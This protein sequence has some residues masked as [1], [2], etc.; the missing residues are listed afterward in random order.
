MYRFGRI[1]RLVMRAALQKGGVQVV[2]VNDPF[3]TLEYMVC[4]AEHLSTNLSVHTV[5]N[6]VVR[7]SIPAY[8]HMLVCVVVHSQAAELGEW[9][10]A[11]IPGEVWGQNSHVLCTILVS[12]PD[13]PQKAE[14]G[15]GV[16]GDVSCHMGQGR[17][18]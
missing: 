8:L 3:L 11:A 5:C 1:G 15:S 9:R 7:Q 2:G 6:S 10:G 14:R 12:F 16:P 17:M 18:P 13:P 4:R